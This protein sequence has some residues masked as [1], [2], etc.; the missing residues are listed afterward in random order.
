MIMLLLFLCQRFIFG[1][2][3]RQ[4]TVRVILIYPLITSICFDAHLCMEMHS[5]LFKHLKIMC[6]S[7]VYVHADDGAI[8]GY[9]QLDLVG[10]S[11][12]FAGVILPL[13]FLGLSTGLSPTSTN[14]TDHFTL[15]LVR[16]FLPGKRNA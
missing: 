1:A 13:F 10:M 3:I 9:D 2:F 8:P 16:A 6:S 5:T 14:T 12:L 7:L 4:A 11:L 15:S